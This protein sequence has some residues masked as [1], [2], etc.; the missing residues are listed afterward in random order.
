MDPVIW[1]E[2]LS[3]HRDVA[4]RHR[5]AAAEVYIGRGYDNDLVL[6]DPQIA[7]NHL[8]IS[9]AETGEL[10][11]EDVGSANGLYLEG[12]RRRQQ[13]IALD[14]NTILRIGNVHLRVRD[15]G[16]PVPREQPPRPSA[17]LWP[18]AAALAAAILG[19]E[20]LSLWLAETGEPKAS[21]YLMPLIGTV[22]IVLA[23]T[24]G[25]AVL[26]R[27]FAGRARFERNLVIALSGLIVFSLYTDFDAFSA[28]ALAWRRPAAYEYV[29]MW[30]IL[31]AV[32]YAHL[33]AL[34]VRPRLGAAAVAVV[35]LLAIAVQTL[36][37]SEA[38]AV[39]GQQSYLH[40]LLPPAVRLA[41]LQDETAFF[42][43]VEAL[44]SG[45]DGDRTAEPASE[46]SP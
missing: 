38:R 13:R 35:A 40:R 41:P 10:L 3:R 23:W 12:D 46:S 9:R 21:R 27:I 31:G 4:A 25:W 34:S 43:G 14:G 6:D 19:M 36:T 16:H 20:T 5:F 22:G 45:L 18:V 32:C 37:Q 39:F 33:Q 8:R 24:A 28:F 7:V 30:G 26:S 44:K 29:A 1:I 17:R 11:A 42:A 15:A 2:I